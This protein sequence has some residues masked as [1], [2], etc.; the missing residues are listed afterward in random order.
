MICMTLHKMADGYEDERATFQ[1]IEEV[2]NC[3]D[4][5]DKNGRTC[6]EIGVK[7][8]EALGRVC[9]TLQGWDFYRYNVSSKPS[10]LSILPALS[11]SPSAINIQ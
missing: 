9:C 2:Q 7:R 3:P 4:R 5:W 8:S 11:V 10:I 6:G 1:F